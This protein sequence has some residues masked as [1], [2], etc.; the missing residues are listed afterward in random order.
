MIEIQIGRTNN[1]EQV[2]F[3]IDQQYFRMTR[4]YS[5]FRRYIGGKQQQ[6]QFMSFDGHVKYHL[7]TSDTL[8]FM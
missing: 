5:N 7:K 8:L 6:V 2:L 3:I 1:T 4:I